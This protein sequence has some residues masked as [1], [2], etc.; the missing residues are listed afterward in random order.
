MRRWE[1]PSQKRARRE[2][3]ERPRACGK[4]MQPIG[5]DKHLPRRSVHHTALCQLAC[6]AFDV[7][8]TRP[9]FLR[10]SITSL[11]PVAHSKSHPEPT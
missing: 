10:F 2:E 7:L 6:V 3:V 9:Q 11:H 1:S 5:L 8:H 4:E